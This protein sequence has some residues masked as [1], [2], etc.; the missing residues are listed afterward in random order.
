[1]KRYA[2]SIAELAAAVGKA[3]ATLLGYKHR[4][5]P[6]GA[7]HKDKQGRYS[8]IAVRRWLKDH[9]YLAAR[10][11]NPNGGAAGPKRA[12]DDTARL[13]KAQADEREHRAAIA[14]LEEKRLRSELVSVEAVRELNRRTME[15]LADELENWVRAL[16][17]ALA[18]KTAVEVNRVM[19]VKVRELLR[20]FA[21][22]RNFSD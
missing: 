20:E 4:G 7:E 8:V 12:G 10:S 3:S 9:G 11:P 2:T 21:A 18:G 15:F 1:M 16:G 19:K 22:R 6:C 14:A 13:R 5:C 17:P